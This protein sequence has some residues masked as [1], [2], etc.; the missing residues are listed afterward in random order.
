MADFLSS[1]S[2][3]G[4]PTHSSREQQKAEEV[5]RAVFDEWANPDGSIARDACVP[6]SLHSHAKPDG[7]T[8]RRACAPRSIQLARYEHATYLHQGLTTLSSGYVSLDASRPWLT[9]WITHSLELLGPSHALQG[10]QASD[11]VGFLRRCQVPGTG[12]FAGGPHPGQIAHLAPTYAAVNTLVTLG[13]P[14]AL[15]AIDRPSLLAFLRRMKQP[16][17][18]FCMHDDGECDVRAP[19]LSSR[20]RSP[21]AHHPSVESAGCRTSCM[22]PRASPPV[23]MLPGAS[24]PVCMLPRAS[25]PVSMLPRVS[26]T[27]R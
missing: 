22:L 23:C 19:A 15:E 25:P 16:D 13:T 1:T 2:D 10:E 11:V 14:A 17:G 24:P 27:R 21:P 20:V 9:Y 8:D 3:E 12:G 6:A 18:S 26:P 4:L 7:H 5:C